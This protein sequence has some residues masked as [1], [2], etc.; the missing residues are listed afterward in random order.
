M[1]SL[2]KREDAV[3]RIKLFKFFQANGSQSFFEKRLLHNAEKR[4]LIESE[5]KRKR[6][7]LRKKQR[8]EDKPVEKK[9]IRDHRPPKEKKKDKKEAPPKK[10][11]EEEVC[12]VEPSDDCQ[13][14]GETPGKIDEKRLE[15]LLNATRAIQTWKSVWRDTSSKSCI[16]LTEVPVTA[17]E[18]LGDDSS[19]PIEIRDDVPDPPSTASFFPLEL[20]EPIRSEDLLDPE[21]WGEY[22]DI[23]ISSLCREPGARVYQQ[24]LYRSY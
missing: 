22:E 5:A 15:R 18:P 20:S 9:V 19:P 4:K 24:G 12:F 23:D 17:E 14:V 6:E 13:I 7:E 8:K 16:D 3:L 11:S 21:G 10:P 2:D 1:V